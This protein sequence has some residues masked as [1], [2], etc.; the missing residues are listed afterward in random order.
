MSDRDVADAWWGDDSSGGADRR[1]NG[2]IDHADPPEPDAGRPARPDRRDPQDPRVRRDQADGDPGGAPRTSGAV[3][4]GSGPDAGRAGDD[5]SPG[6]GAGPTRS[7]A[8]FFVPPPEELPPFEE[9][10]ER[11]TQGRR[12]AGGSVAAASAPV[13]PGPAASAPVAPP[14]DMPPP[15][16]MPDPGRLAGT[17]DT[18]SRRG[19]I[20]PRLPVVVPDPGPPAGIRDPGPVI[21]A[22][23]GIP[24]AP[25]LGRPPAHRGSR[26]PWARV[27]ERSSGAPAAPAR[28][29][30][31][32]RRLA[33]VYDIEGPRVRLGV[34]WFAIAMLGMVLPV[35]AALVFAVAAGFAGRQIVR[36]WG[37]V[38]W[39]ADV[40]A[41]IAAVPVL[42]ALAGL[43]AA[44]VTAGLGLA[45]ALGCALAPDGAR[46]PGGAGRVAAAGILAVALVPA[47]AGASVVLVR[48]E[49]VTAALVLVLVAS[50]YEVGD[51]IVGSGSSTPVEGPL[52]GMTTA[53][54]V[55]LPLA[56]VLVE[57]YDAAGAALLG[58]AAVACPVGQIVASAVLPGAGAHAPALRRIDTLLLLG[59]LWVAAAGAI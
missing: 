59:P 19:A 37:A 3:R 40:A 8:Q 5:G 53:T 58:F 44:L 39:H 31:D 34:A 20:D 1:R 45:V 4:N 14:R 10:V 12:R 48:S 18:A 9:V 13:A 49:S 17:P 7:R 50:A 28:Q 21:A 56:L 15:A 55:A 24:D 41:G 52:A 43:P 11:L 16:G 22:D 25:V 6:P 47:V 2:R 57:P 33:T 35:T 23:D 36:A 42:A 38:P 46:L 30:V 29:P 27:S 32:R 26:S 51:Y 54:L